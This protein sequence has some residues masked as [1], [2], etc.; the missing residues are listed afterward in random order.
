MIQIIGKQG[1]L[2][3][4]DPCKQSG[5]FGNKFLQE[6]GQSK[7]SRLFAKTFAAPDRP[8]C[9]RRAY[10]DNQDSWQKSSFPD[11]PIWIIQIICKSNC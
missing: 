10:L 3:Q 9:K 11:P 5:S 2:Q 6:T 8:L 4:A 1:G 7:S